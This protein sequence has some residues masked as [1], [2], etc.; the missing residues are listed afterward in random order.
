[1]KH[2]SLLFCAIFFTF[3][4][5]YAQYTNIPDSNFEQKLIDFGHDD[6]LD[7]QVL[8]TNIE[9]VNHLNISWSQITD[10]TGIEDFTALTDLYCHDNELTSLDVSS[11]TALTTLYCWN[12]ELTSL[13]VS[14]NT[15]LTALHCYGNEL[16]SLNLDS[17]SALSYLDC[18][19]NELTNLDV[20]T[21][22]DLIR[23]S[24]S[25]NE[26]ISLDVTTNIALISLYCYDNELTNLDVST[27]TAL[28]DLNCSYN[29]LISL[30]VSTNTALTYLDC[31]DNELTSLDV[32]NS[33]ALTFLYC[34]YNE[35]TSLDVSNNAALTDLYCSDNELTSLDVSTNTALTELWCSDNEL[36]SLNLKNGNNTILN[37]F[38]GPFNSNLSCIQVDDV[39]YSNTSSSWYK[40]ASAIYSTDCATASATTETLLEKT[41]IF[42]NTNKE[43]QIKTP[44]IA[45][46]KIYNL[47]GQELLK[48]KL[49]EHTNLLDLKGFSNG[50]YMLQLS[51]KNQQESKKF[52]LY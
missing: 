48:G 26:L 17:N 22:T 36:T 32:S 14:N 50:L 12:N 18:S 46:F 24:C 3:S 27:N 33:T 8:T 41:N 25:S 15:V 31:S 10:L 35:L 23:F 9:N 11:N 52:L 51:H 40:D 42:V 4:S 2:L 19:D 1:M 39:D 38:Y 6:V 7:G 34:T 5:L 45:S 37:F 28:T 30:D 20:S 44:L 16:T 43:V 29:E 21:N 13:D 49:E 47:T